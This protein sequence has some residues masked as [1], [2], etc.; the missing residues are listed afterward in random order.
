MPT[1]SLPCF[2][3]ETSSRQLFHSRF[4]CSPFP[5][6]HLLHCSELFRFDALLALAKRVAGKQNRWYV[7]QGDTLPQRGWQPSATGRGLAESLEGIAENHSLVMLKRVNEEPEYGELLRR[8]IEE[9]SDL[10]GIDVRS[11]YRDGLFTVL[12]TSPLRV[13]PYHIDGEVTLLMQMHGRKSVYIFDGDDREVLPSAELEEFWSGNIYATRYK[14]DLQNRAWRFEL[15]PGVGV[16]TPVAFP[17]WVQNGP[18]IS[19]SVSMNF[20]R[21]SDDRADAYRVN[22]HLRKLGMHPQ[23][24]GKHIAIDH[25]KGEIYRGARWVKKSLDHLH[26][27][28]SHHEAGLTA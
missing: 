11:R 24:P 7:E 14:Q 6:D 16:T 13:T 19:I 3:E 17:H 21:V 4:D 2:R 20:K 28:S 1:D 12:I 5:F 8:M 26:L 18:E 23:E 22:H 15:A 9:L 25:A 27:P 10:T